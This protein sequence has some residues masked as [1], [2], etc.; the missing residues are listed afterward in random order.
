M[1]EVVSSPKHKTSRIPDASKKIPDPDGIAALQ[2]VC[3]NYYSVIF[4]AISFFRTQYKNGCIKS[5]DKI[6]EII[7]HSLACSRNYAKMLVGCYRG[8]EKSIQ[9]LLSHRK[10]WVHFNFSIRRMDE[11][12]KLFDPQ[13][14]I[15][16]PEGFPEKLLLLSN[17]G[18]GLKVSDVTSAMF[19][20]GILRA[21]DRADGAEI[22]RELYDTVKSYIGEFDDIFGARPNVKFWDLFFE[23]FPQCEHTCSCYFSNCICLFPLLD[24]ELVSKL[25]RETRPFYSADTVCFNVESYAMLK[26]YA[27]QLEILEAEQSNPDFKPDFKKEYLKQRIDHMLLPDFTHWSSLRFLMRR[28]AKNGLRSCDLHLAYRL[29]VSCTPNKIEWFFENQIYDYIEQIESTN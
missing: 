12:L 2:E 20:D 6:Y 10:S 1:T 22:S 24:E 8:D 15:V 23:Y 13:K 17:Y 4:L 26:R 9:K 16:V 11:A 18:L 29:L 3:G 19:K 21:A 7:G 27:E 25:L 28:I 5:L 14:K